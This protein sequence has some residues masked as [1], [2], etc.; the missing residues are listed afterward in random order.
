MSDGGLSVGAFAPLV[1]RVEKSA[2]DPTGTD[3]QIIASGNLDD[4]LR[5][6]LDIRVVVENQLRGLIRR[7]VLIFRTSCPL[8]VDYQVRDLGIISGVEGIY[9]LNTAGL[10]AINL[11]DQLEIRK[12]L[13]KWSHPH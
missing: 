10:Y 5:I 13:R 6:A 1:R 11:F 12:K 3:S 2:R 4:D 9:L 7:I 8:H